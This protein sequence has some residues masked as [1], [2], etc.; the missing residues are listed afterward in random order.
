M[1]T[2]PRLDASNRTRGEPVALT[3]MEPDYAAGSAPAKLA[4]GRSE[5][6]A[7]R[8]NSS[9]RDA[10]DQFTLKRV[11]DSYGFG[12]STIPRKSF[13]RQQRRASR[14]YDF[15]SCMTQKRFKAGC[16]VVPGSAPTN[17][18]RQATMPQVLPNYKLCPVASPRENAGGLN[19]QSLGCHNADLSEHERWIR[20]VIKSAKTE[21]YVERFFKH[22]RQIINI[23]RD[24]R[25]RCARISAWKGA[26]NE[27]GALGSIFTKFHSYN[28][29]CAGKRRFK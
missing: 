21:H 8:G 6:G 9:G 12:Q 26:C 13:A 18:A 27:L 5:F 29:A 28:L 22:P 2:F 17:D 20:N 11:R 10:N 7:I 24:E 4:A 16:C 19:D 23:T 1:Q 14:F 3:T 25:R 15:E